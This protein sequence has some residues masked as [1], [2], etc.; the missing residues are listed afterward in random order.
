MMMIDNDM[1]EF[2]ANEKRRV[3]LIESDATAAFR[4]LFKIGIYSSIFFSPFTDLH[5]E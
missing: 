2:D 5:P 1:A 3:S 4:A